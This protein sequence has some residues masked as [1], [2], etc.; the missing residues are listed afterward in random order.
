MAARDF[1]GAILATGKKILQ[2]VGVLRMADAVAEQNC[3]TFEVACLP[4]VQ[5]VIRGGQSKYVTRIRGLGW[6]GRI[7]MCS[8]PG[9]S[10]HHEETYCYQNLHAEAVPWL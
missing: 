10:S 8:S 4:R 5:E 2:R 6:S 1:E 7:L 3:S 9:R